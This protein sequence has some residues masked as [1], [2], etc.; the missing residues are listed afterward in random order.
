MT[1]LELESCDNVSLFS[2]LCT[3]PGWVVL[4]IGTY[5]D[6]PYD[7]RLPPALQFENPLLIIASI[8]LAICFWVF[9]FS[10]LVSSYARF[11]AFMTWFRHR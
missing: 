5:I 11:C 9:V 6:I 7:P 2:L 8:W 3:V 1:R 10:F 4:G